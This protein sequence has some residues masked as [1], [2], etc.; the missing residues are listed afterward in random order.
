MAIKKEEIKVRYTEIRDSKGRLIGYDKVHYATAGA[1]ESVNAEISKNNK[2]I[3]RE[4]SMRREAAR[5]EFEREKIEK[6]EKEYLKRYSFKR[7]LPVYLYCLVFGIENK[8]D[9][10]EMFDLVIRKA[11]K[12]RADLIKSITESYPKFGKIYFEMEDF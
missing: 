4:E 11:G 12:E 3:E 1:L 6:I 5:A 8:P 7:F 9:F 10:Q 2:E